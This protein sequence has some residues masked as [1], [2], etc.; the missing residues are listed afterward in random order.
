M[1]DEVAEVGEANKGVDPNSLCYGFEPIGASILRYVAPLVS[2]NMCLSPERRVE[3]S[4][5]RAAGEVLE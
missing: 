3:K 4:D 5:S 1:G 2:G